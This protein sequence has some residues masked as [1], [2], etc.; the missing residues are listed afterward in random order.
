MRKSL[1]FFISLSFNLGMSSC[2][3]NASKVQ[4]KSNVDNSVDASNIIDLYSNE[5]NQSQ[6]TNKP[7]YTVSFYSIVG[8]SEFCTSTRTVIEGEK[9]SPPEDFERPGY[10][11]K[12]WYLERE[13]INLFDFNDGIY[14]DISIYARWEG[15]FVFSENDDFE[16]K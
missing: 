10:V 3:S 14:D 7:K 1:L 11:F 2:F 12:G 15:D 13:Y 9:V 5:N 4:L 6:Y 8:T 16:F